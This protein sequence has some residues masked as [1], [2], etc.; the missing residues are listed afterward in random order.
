[1]IKAASMLMN[2]I[3]FTERSKKLDMAL[4]ICVQYEK[5]IKM[6]GRSDGAT[7]GEF[8]KYIMETIQDPNLEQ[9]WK[10]YQQ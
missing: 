4:D 6:T 8:A 5:K 1:M 2:H 10:G 7:G 3:G 9:K